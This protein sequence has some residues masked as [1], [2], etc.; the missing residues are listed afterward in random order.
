MDDIFKCNSPSTF[1]PHCRPP[2]KWPIVPT[3]SLSQQSDNKPPRHKTSRVADPGPGQQRWRQPRGAE[4]SGERHGHLPTAALAG[5]RAELVHSPSAPPAAAIEWCYGGTRFVASVSTG[6]TATT[7]LGPRTS[8]DRLSATTER[9]PPCLSSGGAM[10]SGG[11]RFVASLGRGLAATT[12]RGPP[13]YPKTR[14]W[15][16]KLPNNMCAALQIT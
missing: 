5:G 12:E 11:T 1:R 6:N 4:F 15:P 13:N 7:E 2:G 3:V 10:P 16:S 9:G 14:A 8:A